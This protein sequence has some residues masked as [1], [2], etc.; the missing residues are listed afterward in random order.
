MGD[1]T[2]QTGTVAEVVSFADPLTIGN[3]PGNDPYD[4]GT[5]VF[6]PQTHTSTT[7]ILGSG[8]VDAIFAP[9][10]SAYFIDGDPKAALTFTTT[11]PVN[12]VTFGGTI[13]QAGVAY[14]IATMSVTVVPEPSAVM[15]L[16]GLSL[17]ALCRRV[18]A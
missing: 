7:S 9:Q 12:T 3:Q 1:G 18:V 10:G 17:A 13:S 6:G 15:L 4:G 8:T 16:G 11:G 14:P 5:L 2:L